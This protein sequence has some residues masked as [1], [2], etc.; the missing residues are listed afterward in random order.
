MLQKLDGGRGPGRGGFHA[1]DCEEAPAGAPKLTLGQALDAA[2]HPGTRLCS[3]RG[4]AQV[5]KRRSCCS[6]RGVHC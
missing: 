3:L 4:A 6:G 2:E 1:A 5:L